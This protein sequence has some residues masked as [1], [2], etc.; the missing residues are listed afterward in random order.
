[1][2]LYSH[3]V[4]VTLESVRLV[5]G[6]Y[7]G[8]MVQ[9]ETVPASTWASVD[10]GR[11]DERWVSLEAEGHNIHGE[12]DF[13]MRFEPGSVLDAGCGTGRVAI[14]LARRGVDAVGVDLDGPMIDAAQA[15]A[16]EL[17]FRVGDL[18]AVAFDRVFDAIVMAG[19]VMIF[20]DPGSESGVVSNMAKHLA[21]GGHLIAGFQLGRSVSAGE[22]ASYASN[23]GLEPV[24]HCSTWEQHPSADGDTYAVFVHRRPLM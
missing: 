16:P 12:A 22:Y 4:V 14:E 3:E 7:G 19:N 17:D 15:K 24:E 18:A 13:V 9:D 1:M 5:P 21:P 20:V 10:T 2:R 11:Y 6:T 8:A 23:A